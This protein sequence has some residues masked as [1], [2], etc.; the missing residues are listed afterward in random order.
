MMLVTKK[1]Y[2]FYWNNCLVNYICFDG[3]F[4]N[5][6]LLLF[7]NACS[8]NPNV[9]LTKKKKKI[10]YKIIRIYFHLKVSLDWKEYLS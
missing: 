5:S 3:S 8:L 7:E 2:L 6:S 1:I 4:D 10:R 9:I